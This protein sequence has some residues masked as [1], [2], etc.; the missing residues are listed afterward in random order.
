MENLKIKENEL[1]SEL[2]NLNNYIVMLMKRR[3]VLDAKLSEVVSKISKLEEQQTEVIVIE[4]MN[5]E[6]K[7]K[8]TKMNNNS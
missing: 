1:R 3:R 5:E 8:F 4:D 6:W 2:D 7:K